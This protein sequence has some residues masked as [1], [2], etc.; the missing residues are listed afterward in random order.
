VLRTHC[1]VSGAEI[2]WPGARLCLNPTQM[3]FVQNIDGHRTI[4]QIIECVAQRSE[5]TGAGA[6]YLEEFGRNLFR[7]LWRI[8]F[9]AMALAPAR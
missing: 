2:F 3:P 7:S 9:V 5:W 8:D 1:G 6:T 4:R